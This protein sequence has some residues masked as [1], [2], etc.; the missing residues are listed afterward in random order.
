MNIWED[1]FKIKVEKKCDQVR[2]Y[3]PG[4]ASSGD[5][6]EVG[7]EVMLE[8]CPRGYVLGSVVEGDSVCMVRPPKQLRLEWP[9]PL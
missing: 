2:L 3:V 7:L 4:S 9:I 8:T 5:G 6:I 1:I